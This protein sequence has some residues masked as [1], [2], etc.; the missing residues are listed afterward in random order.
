MGEVTGTVNVT[1]VEASG[2]CRV[3]LLP[4]PA[5]VAVETARAAKARR[6]DLCMKLAVPR[7]VR[8]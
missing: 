2:T 7:A 4:Q 8:M 1:V 3:V 6:A 5:H